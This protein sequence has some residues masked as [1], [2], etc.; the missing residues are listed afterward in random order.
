MNVRYNKSFRALSQSI[1][2]STTHSS[3]K[4]VKCN[5]CLSIWPPAARPL[6]VILAH[7]HPPT[8]EEKAPTAY[9]RQLG[10]F[11]QLSKGAK[12]IKYQS[13]GL[14][15]RNFF[16]F[17]R[18]QPKKMFAPVCAQPISTCVCLVRNAPK[19]PCRHLCARC[20]SF[21]EFN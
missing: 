12:K 2:Y 10:H 17:F 11:S 4:M 8:K 9:H 3:V 6:C 1:V 21:W 14:P 13:I 18:K 5:Q 16:I 20:N 19:G 15:L 7:T